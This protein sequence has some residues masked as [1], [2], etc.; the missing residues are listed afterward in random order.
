MEFKECFLNI[1]KT[2]GILIAP[3][4][5]LGEILNY[6]FNFDKVKVIII[7]AI[8]LWLFYREFTIWDL[9]KEKLKNE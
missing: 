4:I 8:I 2:I 6:C 3:C 5:I 9:K 7:S 1:L